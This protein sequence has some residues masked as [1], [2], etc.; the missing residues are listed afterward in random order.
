MRNILSLES[1]H[2]AIFHMKTL[3]EHGAF[4]ALRGNL[5]Q[6]QERERYIAALQT[7]L[8]VLEAHGLT[9]DRTEG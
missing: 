3:L 9:L 8:D 7:A 1:A 4:D 2:L 5:Q 6:Q